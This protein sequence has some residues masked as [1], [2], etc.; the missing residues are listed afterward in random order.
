MSFSKDHPVYMRLKQAI[1]SGEIPSGRRL[2]LGELSTHFRTSTAPLREALTRL[3]AEDL[4]HYDFSH[5]YSVR[6]ISFSELSNVLDLMELILLDGLKHLEKNV[7]FESLGRAAEL[8]NDTLNAQARSSPARNDLHVA[9]KGCRILLSPTVDRQM[10][11]LSILTLPFQFERSGYLSCRFSDKPQTQQMVQ[12]LQ[13][14]DTAKVCS[15]LQELFADTR[16]DLPAA[17]QLYEQRRRINRI[18]V[19]ST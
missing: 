9:I 1:S 13:S 16:R 11:K 15:I 3:A 10:R 14:G 19:E 7:T 6:E 12:A 17:Y 2:K 8:I 18:A 4:V 5:G